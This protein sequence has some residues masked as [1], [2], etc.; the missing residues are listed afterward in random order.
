MLGFFGLGTGC[1]CVYCGNELL[2]GH[3]VLLFRSKIEGQVNRQ[4]LSSGDF[5]T[6]EGFQLVSKSLAVLKPSDH[7]Q[8]LGLR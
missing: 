8:S 4:T 2:P 1:H 7:V 5:L 3:A 6:L